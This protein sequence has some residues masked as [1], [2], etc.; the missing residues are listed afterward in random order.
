MSRICEICGKKPMTGSRIVRHGLEKAKGGIGLH[1]TGI[2]GRR[3]VPNLKTVH[4]RK[5]DGTT[6]HMTVCASCIKAGR[7]TKAGAA[8]KVAPKA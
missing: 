2:S 4:A 8:K 1:T 5:A 3:F 6:C 7:V